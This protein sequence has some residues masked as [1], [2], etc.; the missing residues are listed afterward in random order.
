MRRYLILPAVYFV[1][2]VVIVL[3]LMYGR[4]NSMGWAI[5]P[6][7]Y[8]PASEVA[9]GGGVILEKFV[10]DPFYLSAYDIIMFVVMGTLWYWIVGWS[11]HRAIGLLRPAKNVEE[12][13]RIKRER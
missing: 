13:G 11:I 12:T 6:Y 8:W 9:M 2:S 7:L 4:E 5:V 1:L 10:K 3:Q